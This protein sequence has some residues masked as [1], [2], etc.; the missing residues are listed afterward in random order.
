MKWALSATLLPW[1][2]GLVEEVCRVGDLAQEAFVVRQK[3]SS[4][5]Y[6]DWQQGKQ[7]YLVSPN[8]TMPRELPL[9][10]IN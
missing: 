5:G 3:Q 1:N 6:H 7:A 4:P 2:T 8:G 10:L 9:W